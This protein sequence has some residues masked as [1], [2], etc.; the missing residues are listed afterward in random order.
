MMIAALRKALQLLELLDTLVFFFY[1]L[2]LHFNLEELLNKRWI[3]FYIG[4]IRR[5]LVKSKWNM[6]IGTAS[7]GPTMHTQ[8]L[9]FDPQNA[10]L[11]AKCGGTPL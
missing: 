2:K 7:K 8:G 6:K 3:A 4:L 11:K 5:Y 9:E 10:N 1:V